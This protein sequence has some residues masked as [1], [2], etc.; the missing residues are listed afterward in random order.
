MT[1]TKNCEICHK[2]FQISEH[3]LFHIPFCFLCKD[4]GIE[5]NKGK[6]YKCKK[7][8]PETLN[9]KGYG[10]GIKENK[11]TLFECE[12]CYLLEHP[13][14]SQDSLNDVLGT[15]E[16]QE[17]T[18]V[19]QVIDIF[20]KALPEYVKL[21]NGKILGEFKLDAILIIFKFF[22]VNITIIIALFIIRYFILLD[23]IGKVK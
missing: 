9:E 10:Y 16:T 13:K 18:A 15:I 23:I 5:L 19:S 6:C 17:P 12:E 2:D 7:E 20:N 21:L 4:K 8:I 1:I 3:S 11:V 22:L 14:I